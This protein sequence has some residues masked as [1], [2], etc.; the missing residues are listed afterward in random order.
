MHQCIEKIHRGENH[1]LVEI[2]KLYC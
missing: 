1:E 2:I